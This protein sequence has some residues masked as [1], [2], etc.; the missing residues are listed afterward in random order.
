MGFHFQDCPWYVLC[1]SSK[2]NTRN[3]MN[4]LFVV[5]PIPL[6]A[7]LHM[8]VECRL[9]RGAKEPK[10][11]RPQNVMY[12]CTCRPL[13]LIFVI[14]VLAFL[15]HFTMWLRLLLILLPGT[16]ATSLWKHSLIWSLFLVSAPGLAQ[17]PPPPAA[18]H[19][20]LL[21]SNCAYNISTSIFSYPLQL[22]ISLFQRRFAA[23][24]PSL[25][26]CSQTLPDFRAS[27]ASKQP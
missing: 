5:G 7:M 1:S 4:M 24:N 15:L 9:L 13:P 16:S 2:G 20:A 26:S 21:R 19:I 3:S 27:K 14:L 10:Y 25:N 23:L 12:V 11:T 18:D 17:S 22:I 8:N 6:A